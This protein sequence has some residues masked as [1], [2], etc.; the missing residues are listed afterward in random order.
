MEKTR[1]VVYTESSEISDKVPV[2]KIIDEATQD[3]SNDSGRKVVA[4]LSTVDELRE[5]FANHFATVDSYPSNHVRRVHMYNAY[6]ETYD[7]ELDEW[8]NNGDGWFSDLDPDEVKKLMG[9]ED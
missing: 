8:V 9:E 1:F 6:G 2:E 4:T 7:E 5:Y 3:S